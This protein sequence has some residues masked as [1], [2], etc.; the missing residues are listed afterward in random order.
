[1]QDILEQQNFPDPTEPSAIFAENATDIDKP[2]SPYYAQGVQVNYTAPAKWWNWLWQH[3]TSWLLQSKN[4]RASMLSELINILTAAFITPSSTD[5]HQVSEGINT[6]AYNICDAYDKEEI[7][8]EI[9]GVMVTHKK[10]QPYVVGM[11]LYIPST[12]LL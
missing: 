10:N 12:E 1:M 11:T 9:D 6:I 3:M 7:T 4:D 5:N 8:E 2:A